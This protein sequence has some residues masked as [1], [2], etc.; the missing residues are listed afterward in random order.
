MYNSLEVNE[1][2]VK[3]KL[4]AGEVAWRWVGQG[5]RTRRPHIASALRQLL[6]GDLG[7]AALRLGKAKA[8]L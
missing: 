2:R 4:V 6:C 3:A 5:W 1:Y 7:C 8:K